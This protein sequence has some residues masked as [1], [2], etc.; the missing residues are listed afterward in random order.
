MQGSPWFFVAWARA[1]L[2][3]DFQHINGDDFTFD[4]A[5]GVGYRFNDRF[6][7]TTGA[8]VLNLN[9]DS[10]I[11]PG[12]NFDWVVNDKTRI[13]LYGPMPMISYKPNEDWSFSMRGIPGGGVWNITNDHGDSKSINLTSYQLGVFAS[14]RITGEF[15]I[16]AGVGATVFNNIKYSDPDGSHKTLDE[17]MGSGL[18]GQ[19][20]LSLK[21]W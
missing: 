7:L 21:T 12:I 17:D 10:R 8:T 1:E 6:S 11:I 19:I 4:I 15:W 9:G 3:S 2:A 20:G 16:N 13:G 18:F 5:G 14:R